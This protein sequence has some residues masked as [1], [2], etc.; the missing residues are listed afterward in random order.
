MNICANPE[1]LVM[2]MGVVLTPIIS[3]M[4]V[5]TW[6]NEN[7]QRFAIVVAAIAGVLTIQFCPGA[8]LDLTR[9]FEA[10]LLAAGTNQ[11]AFQAVMKGL[12]LEAL[13]DRLKGIEKKAV[14]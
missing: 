13:F 9:Y 1:L 6:A 3:W 11:V 10:A 5:E 2:L 14:G 7:K 4:K 12:N 8:Q